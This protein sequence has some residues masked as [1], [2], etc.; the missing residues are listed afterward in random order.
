MDP[1][2]KRLN[3]GGGLGGRSPPSFLKGGVWGAEPPQSF[4]FCV[5]LNV[6]RVVGSV[7]EGGKPFP[8]KKKGEGPREKKRESGRAQKKKG[9]GSGKKKGESPEKKK[10]ENPRMGSGN[11]A[12][13]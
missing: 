13:T 9:E 2:A 11:Q 12:K 6:T 10:G 3:F 8:R 7:E 5:W 1:G 4:F